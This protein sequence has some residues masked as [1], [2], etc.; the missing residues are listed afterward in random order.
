MSAVTANQAENAVPASPGRPAVLSR[1]RLAEAAIEMGIG[2]LTVRGLAARLGVGHSALYRW[3]RDRDEILDLVSDTLLER[4][5]A[6]LGQE[7]EDWREWLVRFARSL[8]A[9]FDPIIGEGGIALFPR[10]TPRYQELIGEVESRFAQSGI[11]KAVAADTFQ[12]FFL[13]VWG[14][15]AVEKACA[16]QIDHARHFDM[17]LDALVRGLPVA[18]G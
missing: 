7:P 18:G 1:E 4:A 8:R 17:M 2:K 10:T 13:T 3:V 12:I 5:V 14:W 9:E 16:D 11:D 15:L 6:K